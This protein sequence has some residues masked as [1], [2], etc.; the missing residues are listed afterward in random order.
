MYLFDLDGTLVDS[1]GIWTNV[2]RTFLARR[3]MP[4]TKEYYEGVAH[5]IL[6]LAAVFTK[7]YCHLDESCEEIVRE[8]MELARDSYAHVALKP[9]ARELLD[10]LTADGERLA[11]FTSAV[12][13]HC[14]TALEKYSLRPYFER[15]VFAHDLGVDKGTADAFR[16]ACAQLGVAPK[17]CVFLDDSVKSCRAAKEA[18]LYVIGVYDPFFEGT[19]HEMPDACHRFINSFAEL[20]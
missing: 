15:V 2:D 4:Y 5:T 19:K 6:P 18:G 17:D 14:E 9:Y 8:W 11:V 12:P 16:Q 10:K 20:L 13:S 1:N 7:E 3:G